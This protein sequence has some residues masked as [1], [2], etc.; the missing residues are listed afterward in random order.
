MNTS[1][2]TDTLVVQARIANTLLNMGSLYYDDI[3]SLTVF[4][5][6]GTPEDF[7]V[8]AELV[9][10]KL[11]PNPVPLFKG[12]ALFGAKDF[13]DDLF[14]MRDSA[15]DY[16]YEVN[17][18]FMN[19]KDR[20]HMEAFQLERFEHELFIA[21]LAHGL[22]KDGV[23][24]HQFVLYS[25]EGSIQDFRE[26]GRVASLSLYPGFDQIIERDDYLE[27]I[28]RMREGKEYIIAEIKAEALGMDVFDYIQSGA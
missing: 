10:D 1:L 24:Q 2:L 21:H 5:Q 26:A 8:A 13:E 9:S 28:V 3:I 18:E 11:F 7:R 16:L 20:A 19:Y 25:P 17:D 22:I 14:T 4:S 15:D 12:G 27:N 6:G 23:H